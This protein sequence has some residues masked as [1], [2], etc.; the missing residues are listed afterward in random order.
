MPILTK[1]V[2]VGGKI[3][4]QGRAELARCSRSALPGG[5][6]FQDKIEGV[7]GDSQTSTS[8]GEP[9]AGLQLSSRIRTSRSSKAANAAAL[10]MKVEEEDDRAAGLEDDAC[11]C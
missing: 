5:H 4:R 2:E 1:N 6:F 7:T 8:T 10:D 9:P 3:E 11:S